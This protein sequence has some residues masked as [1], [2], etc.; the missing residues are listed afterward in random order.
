MISYVTVYSK[1]F[2]FISFGFLVL[3][4]QPYCMTVAVTRF[5]ED[6]ETLQADKFKSVS[7]TMEKTEK[8]LCKFKFL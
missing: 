7:I 4:W 2:P 3:I 8:P 6:F 5:Q 1:C